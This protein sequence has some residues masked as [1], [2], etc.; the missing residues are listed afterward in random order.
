[1]SR[2]RWQARHAKPYALDRASFQWVPFVAALLVYAT[3]V[4][5]LA[6]VG[7]GVWK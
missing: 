1:M 2:A 3:F 5:A 4:F 7:G 6:V